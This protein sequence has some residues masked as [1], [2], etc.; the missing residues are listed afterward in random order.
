MVTTVRMRDELVLAGRHDARGPDAHEM[1]VLDERADEDAPAER[2]ALA[3]DRGL[4]AV[5]VVR[6]MQRRFDGT[7]AAC[8][9]LQPIRPREPGGVGR[10]ARDQGRLRE[11]LETAPARDGRGDRRCGDRIHL[12]RNRA[13]ISPPRGVPVP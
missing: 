6:E 7:G 9:A 11:P 1:A 2:D 8:R 12:V 13:R 5:G 10:I 4:D 3:A